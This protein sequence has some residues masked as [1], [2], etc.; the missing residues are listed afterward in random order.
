[1]LMHLLLSD[2]HH[3]WMPYNW[4][5][6]NYFLLDQHQEH[7]CFSFCLFK[8]RLVDFSQEQNQILKLQTSFHQF[9]TWLLPGLRKM[10]TSGIFQHKIM[11]QCWWALQFC[12]TH[13]IFCCCGRCFKPL[14]YGIMVL[15]GRCYCLIAMLMQLL[16]FCLADVIALLHWWLG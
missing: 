8:C 16:F 12:W 14:L 9:Q 10:L 5:V 1:M 6:V 4:E 15:F 7:G 11:S 2:T 13:G 3:L